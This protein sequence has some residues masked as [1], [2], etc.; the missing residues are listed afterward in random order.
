[1]A[2]T[3]TRSRSIKPKLVQQTFDWDAQPNRLGTCRN[4]SDV[5]LAPGRNSVFPKKSRPLPASK[6]GAERIGR[7]EHAGGLMETVLSRYGISPEEF[8][9][10]VEVLRATVSW[11]PN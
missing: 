6:A 3:A 5:A 7:C 2:T 1:M 11:N 10:A 8:R 9:K 4:E